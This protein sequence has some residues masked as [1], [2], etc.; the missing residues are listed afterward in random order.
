V[1]SPGGHTSRCALYVAIREPRP[2][3]ASE[4][5]RIEGLA[6]TVSNHLEGAAVAAAIQDRIDV[7]EAEEEL[8]SR[9]AA[10]LMEEISRPLADAKRGLHELTDAL[11]GT[12]QHAMATSIARDLQRVDEIASSAL[13]LHEIRM[14]RRPRLVLAD[15]DLAVIAHGVAERFRPSHGDRLVVHAER[16]IRGNWSDLQLRRAVTNLV[17]NALQHGAAKGVVTIST[18]RG[19]NG[20]ELSV[21]NEGPT[22][23]PEKQ[24]AMFRPFSLALPATVRKELGWGL[25]LTL[26]WGY[27]D[28]HGG[29]VMVE[30]A[31]S[32]G[33][34]FT[35]SI[36]YDSRP[37]ADSD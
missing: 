30:S 29:R 10:R 25:G 7:I 16:G 14:G 27:V 3:T 15:C 26:A 6:Q 19:R 2:F 12:G 28:A 1:V 18:R 24:A 11:A 35:L 5:R 32:K 31:P 37:Y 8:R 23:S 9:F 33:T 17:S 36:P 22:I 34:T 13:D 4:R 21:H 20:A